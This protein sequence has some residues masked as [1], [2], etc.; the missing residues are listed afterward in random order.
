M[1]QRH[2]LTKKL[3]YFKVTLYKIYKLANKHVA[4]FLILFAKVYELLT[5]LNW[6]VY[7]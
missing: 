5:F 4:Y 1:E 3:N 2:L 6:G 7:F